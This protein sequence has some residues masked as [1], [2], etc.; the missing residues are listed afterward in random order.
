M[1]QCTYV[2]VTPEEIVTCQRPA[3]GE[4]GKV[5]EEYFCPVHL[6]LVEGSVLKP[7]EEKGDQ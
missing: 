4:L 5:G 7:K 6:L 2:A 1:R 3:M